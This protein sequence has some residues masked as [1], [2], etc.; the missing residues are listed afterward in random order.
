MRRTAP[1]RPK[2]PRDAAWRPPDIKP[3]LVMPRCQRGFSPSVRG[4]ALSSELAVHV[5]D[6]GERCESRRFRARYERTHR[7]APDAV[8]LRAPP[9][10]RR[11]AA[12][13]TDRDQDPGEAARSVAE[14]PR[15]LRGGAT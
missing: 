7:D 1:K 14:A 12:L 8:R 11:E 3:I 9:F 2:T 4:Q 5:Q 15:A 13:G 6:H 10:C